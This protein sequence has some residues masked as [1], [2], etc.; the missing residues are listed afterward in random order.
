MIN[1]IKTL[2]KLLLGRGVRSSYSQFGEDMVVSSLFRSKNPGV[3]VDVGAYHPTL[4]STTY[5]L[6]RRGWRGLVIDP[7]RNMRML[8]SIFRPRDT[9]IEAAVGNAGQYAY[10]QYA[11]AAYNSLSGAQVRDLE[12]KKG[13]KPM[14][15]YSVSVKPLRDILAARG[16]HSIDYLN[17]DVEGMDMQVLE[18]HD[19]NIRPKVITV[20][21]AAFHADAPTQSLAYSFL[22]GKG[23]SLVGLAGLTLV[24]KD[25]H[26]STQKC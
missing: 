6:Y 11:D 14:L 19:W 15:S 23:Y 13:V 9:F 21:D 17:V 1:I 10:Y 26:S 24:F 22:K 7:N 18:T 16:I 20:E 5:A 12:E 8:F 2:L 4:Y 25:T 3:Y